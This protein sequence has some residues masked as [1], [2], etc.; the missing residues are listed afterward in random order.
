MSPLSPGSCSVLP[1][2]SPS[3]LDS[4][5]DAYAGVHLYATMEHYRKQLDPCPPHPPFAEENK[6]VFSTKDSPLDIGDDDA[7]MPEQDA[8]VASAP[9]KEIVA[10]VVESI[11]IEDVAAVVESEPESEAAT[12][13]DMKPK[14]RTRRKPVS[15]QT[16]PLGS[17][18]PLVEIAEDRA[19]RYQ[20]AHPRAR[21]PLSQLRAYFLWHNGGVD[22]AAMARLLDI[23]EISATTYVLS[24]IRYEGLPYDEERLLVELALPLPPFL[25]NKFPLA[26]QAILN[27]KARAKMT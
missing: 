26:N 13:Q 11:E 12:E 3:R 6:P 7:E 18:H 10:E 19:L 16:P 8:L 23:K 21:A 2:I 24:A 20:A 27:M 14:S 9:S 15:K 5:S 25:R 22:P 17:R 4:A 1:T